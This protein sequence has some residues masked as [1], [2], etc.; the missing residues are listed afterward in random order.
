MVILNL[1][2][3]MVMKRLGVAE[4]H[5]WIFLFS[6]LIY[7]KRAVV[8]SSFLGRSTVYSM[9]LSAT[10]HGMLIQI[11]TF[12]F[13]DFW[14]LF[15]KQSYKFQANKCGHERAKLP[16]IVIRLSLFSGLVKNTKQRSPPNPQLPI[17]PP[18]AAQMAYSWRKD[19]K[20]AERQNHFD[21]PRI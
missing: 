9:V 16:S 19:N 8:F 1:K 20:R 3:S 17:L 2:S 7:L 6:D 11:Q 4:K 15:I 18:R 21:K 5:Y 10:L 13:L 12:I 14:R